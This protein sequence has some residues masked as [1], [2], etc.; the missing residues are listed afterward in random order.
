MKETNSIVRWEDFQKAIIIE[1]YGKKKTIFSSMHAQY[2]AP[3]IFKDHLI[4]FIILNVIG[5]TKSK[6]ED[7]TFLQSALTIT[8]V[9]LNNAQKY[10]QAY[11]EA[12]MDETTGVYNRKYFHEL[13]DEEYK[14]I[15]IHL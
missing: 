1:V 3:L 11:M 2:I 10:E 9:A 5:K 7:L 6:N 14:N 13:L 12:R 15:E 8:S 4:G